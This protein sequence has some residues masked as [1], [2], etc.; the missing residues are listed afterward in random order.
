M[1]LQFQ[2]VYQQAENWY[3]LDSELPWDVKKLREDLFSLIETCK[4]P[5]IFCDTCDANDVLLS[6]G[7]EEEEFLFPVGGFYHKEK[8]LIFVCMWE[9][10]EQVLKTLLHEFRHA[11]QH[12]REVLYVG[13]ES[14]EERWI[15]K[16]ARAF[17]E[18]KLDEYKNRKVM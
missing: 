9:G 5:V 17:A 11:M 12:K 8:Q 4:T 3:V 18:R 2:N 1:E 15:E 14:Y 7:E 10:Y 6:L 16:D 13:S